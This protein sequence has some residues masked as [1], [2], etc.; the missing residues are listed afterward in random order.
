[1]PRETEPG[2]DLDRKQVQFYLPEIALD[3]LDYLCRRQAERDGVKPARLRSFI[4]RLLIR[5][6][7][8]RERDREEAEHAEGSE[9]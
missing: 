4:V 5:Q 1:M 9:K 3:E 8:H 2:T 7:Y 6:A